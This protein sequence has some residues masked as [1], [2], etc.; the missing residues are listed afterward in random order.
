MGCYGDI[1]LGY[2]RNRMGMEY[3]RDI[4]GIYIMIYHISYIVHVTMNYL[5][6]SIV[7]DCDLCFFKCL[8]DG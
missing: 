1:F 8:G 5:I 3:N 2:K 6:C 4:I 7:L